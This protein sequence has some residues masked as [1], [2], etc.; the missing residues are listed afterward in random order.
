[1]SSD[2]GTGGENG[3]GGVDD[4]GDDPAVLQPAVVAAGV[5]SSASP[6]SFFGELSDGGLTKQWQLIR[7]D[8]TECSGD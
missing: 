4:G 7:E 5:M 6:S 3:T 1:M 8:S 2:S